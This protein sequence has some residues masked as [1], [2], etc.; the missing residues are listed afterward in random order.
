MAYVTHD[1]LLAIL[2]DHKIVVIR[3]PAGT[4]VEVSESEKVG[5]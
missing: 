5:S 3:A 1:D 2:A 4:K